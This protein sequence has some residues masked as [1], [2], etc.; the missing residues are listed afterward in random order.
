[1]HDSK[2]PTRARIGKGTYLLI[3]NSLGTDTE[4][5]NIQLVNTCSKI[6]KA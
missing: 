5:G 4:K 2:E 6:I 3:K 1:M